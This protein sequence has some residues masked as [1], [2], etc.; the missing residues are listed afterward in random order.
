MS[1]RSTDLVPVR[2]DEISHLQTIGVNITWF[3]TCLL[4]WRRPLDDTFTSS[5]SRKAINKCASRG[6]W[7]GPLSRNLI[8]VETY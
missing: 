2:L 3:A 8:E 5:G 6:A 1:L 7:Q 4:H